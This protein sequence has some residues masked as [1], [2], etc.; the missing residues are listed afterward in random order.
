MV[1]THELRSAFAIADRL[2]LLH[3]GRFL[4][5]DTPERVRQCQEPVVRGFLERRP[6]ESEDSAEK[7]RRF[8]DDL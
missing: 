7:F 6:Q 4:V 2:A 5:V 1:V 8:L 3:D